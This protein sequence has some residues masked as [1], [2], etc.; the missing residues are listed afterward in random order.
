MS[1]DAKIYQSMRKPACV[2]WHSWLHDGAF[3]ASERRM[4]LGEDGKG[5]VGTEGS[6]GLDSDKGRRRAS[7]Q[8]EPSL[9]MHLVNR[10]ERGGGGG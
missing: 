10:H 7:H 1:E 2:V 4:V 6:N 8:V 5:M 3:S 9:D